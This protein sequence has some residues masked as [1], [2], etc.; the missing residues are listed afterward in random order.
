MPVNDP[1]LL[2]ERLKGKQDI[3]PTIP[4]PAQ[5]LKVGDQQKFWV[6][7]SDTD[8]KRQADATLRYINDKLYFWIENGS[9]R[10]ARDAPPGGYLCQ[11]NLPHRPRILRQRVDPRGG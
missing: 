2:A 4:A 7:N 8:V 3:A 1:I 9:V 11:Q 5:P 10:R 6:T